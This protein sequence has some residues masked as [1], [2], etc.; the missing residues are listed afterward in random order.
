MGKFLSKETTY[1]IDVSGNNN[2]VLMLNGVPINL[3]LILQNI[4][5]HIIQEN[6]KTTIQ[7][8]I[9]AMIVTM[10]L[11]IL[12]MIILLSYTIKWHRRSWE[13]HV[14]KIIQHHETIISPN[15]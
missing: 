13:W 14:L 4:T 7:I 6:Q 3:S 2:Y 11:S 5:Q 9:M 10:I 12:I 1:A 15:K 8:T